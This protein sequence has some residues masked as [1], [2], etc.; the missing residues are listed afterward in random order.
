MSNISLGG[1]TLL[2]VINFK[3]VYS[4]ALTNPDGSVDLVEASPWS[5]FKASCW[6][7]SVTLPSQLPCV[8][9]KDWSTRTDFGL[10]R[11]PAGNIIETFNVVLQTNKG[12]LSFATSVVSDDLSGGNIYFE[13]V[14]T[15]PA[16]EAARLE[17]VVQNA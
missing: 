15:I 8:L 16:E 5:R 7:K 2:G 3:G 13:K 1:R 17:F 11:T 4:L 10:E 9:E 14:S 12:P 6:I